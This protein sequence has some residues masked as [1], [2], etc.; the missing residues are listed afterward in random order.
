MIPFCDFLIYS[1]YMYVLSFTA[2]SEKIRN[3][4]N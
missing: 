2:K 4:Y 1:V 3:T